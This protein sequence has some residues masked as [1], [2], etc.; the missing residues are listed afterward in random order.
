MVVFIVAYDISDDERRL[1]MMRSLLALGYSRVQRSVYMYKRG[2]E[3]VKRATIER[4]A[5]II[6]PTTDSV[7]IIPLPGNMANSIIKLGVGGWDDE[8]ITI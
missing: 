2:F 3:A 7:I 6:D 5:R 4:A 8:V 1:K